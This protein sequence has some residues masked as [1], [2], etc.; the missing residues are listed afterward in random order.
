VEID[1]SWAEVREREPMPPVLLLILDWIV[2]A[3]VL[4]ML[5]WHLLQYVLNSAAPSVVAVPV[6]VPVPVPARAVAIAWTSAALKAERE[7][8]PPL[9]PL[10]ALWIRAA[11]VPNLADEARGPWQ[12]AQSVA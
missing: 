2:E 3:E 12:P 1:C 10:M 5:L 4:P 7:P 6:P 9:L 11:V 8:I